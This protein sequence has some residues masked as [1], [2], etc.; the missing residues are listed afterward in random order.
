MSIALET[1]R[2]AQEEPAV[3]TEPDTDN[4]ILVDDR[5]DGLEAINRG[6]C[7]LEYLVGRAN[8]ADF[9]GIGYAQFAC[10]IHGVPRFH[11]VANRQ[12]LPSDT[13][14]VLSLANQVTA[15]A[16]GRLPV[17]RGT[18][19]IWAGMD[20]FI[21]QVQPPHPRPQPAFRATPYTEE[22]WQAIFADGSRRLI[23]PDE[24][25]ALRGHGSRL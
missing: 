5:E 21:W 8:S 1:P 13:A 17:S 11:D 2:R 25:A 23:T 22:D 7:L 14:H 18:I 10:F 16:G 19:L 3:S 4:P 6:I 12:Y 20:T 9:V 15:A 24:L